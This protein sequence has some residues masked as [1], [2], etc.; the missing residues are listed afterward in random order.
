MASSWIQLGCMEVVGEV[1][2]WSRMY[3]ERG[4]GNTGLGIQRPR[5]IVTVMAP[6]PNITAAK[7][8]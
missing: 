7:I 4:D 3:N 6:N 2:E 1:E 8:K 5:L